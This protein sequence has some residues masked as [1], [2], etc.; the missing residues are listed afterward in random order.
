MLNTPKV[1]SGIGIA[2]EIMAVCLLEHEITY[3]FEC[4]S[5]WPFK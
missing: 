2:Y 1:D 4:L 3:T 5:Y